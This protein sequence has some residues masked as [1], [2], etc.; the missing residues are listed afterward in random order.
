ME[1]SV[2]I[3]TTSCV[4]RH[5]LLSVCKVLGDSLDGLAPMSHYGRRIE[6]RKSPP[7]QA[8]TSE[9]TV[10]GNL[11]RALPNAESQAPY[12]SLASSG[13][14]PPTSTTISR[15][16]PQMGHTEELHMI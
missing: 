11:S 5:A 14:Q 2:L 13:S 16:L 4:A 15:L 1:E 9:D 8:K 10:Y 7:R 6:S 12:A 3:A